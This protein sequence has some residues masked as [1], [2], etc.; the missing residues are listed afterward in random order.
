M[1]SNPIT[2]S[3]QDVDERHDTLFNRV[4]VIEFLL[5]HRT[6]LLVNYGDGEPGRLVEVKTDMIVQGKILLRF[7]VSVVIF[8]FYAA[9]SLDL[10]A[11]VSGM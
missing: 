6:E 11:T 7:A 4:T 1:I 9:T 5:E 3:C 2:I 10:Y 8:F